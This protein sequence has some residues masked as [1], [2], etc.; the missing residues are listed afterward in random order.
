MSFA[1]SLKTTM[2]PELANFCKL[3]WYGLYEKWESDFYKRKDPIIKQ[4][5]W[6]IEAIFFPHPMHKIR[7]VMDIYIP[8]IYKE[9]NGGRLELPFYENDGCFGG[10]RIYARNANYN[11]IAFIAEKYGGKTQIMLT[12]DYSR[13]PILNINNNYFYHLKLET[14]YLKFDQSNGGSYEGIDVS[15]VSKW[16][17]WELLNYFTKF[18]QNNILKANNNQ[19]GIKKNST[20][21]LPLHKIIKI[22]IMD[23]FRNK[24][25]VRLIFSGQYQPEFYITLPGSWRVGNISLWRDYLKGKKSEGKALQ[26]IASS[27]ATSPKPIYLEPP[28]IS[29]EDGGKRKYGLIPSKNGLENY[30]FIKKTLTGVEIRYE[31]QASNMVSVFSLFPPIIFLVL[32]ISLLTSLIN[33]DKSIIT[34]MMGCYISYLIAIMAYYYT[35]ITLKNNGYD[36]PHR[37]LFRI[38]MFVIILAIIFSVIIIVFYK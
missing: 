27:S 32:S 18:I 28:I 24:I 30:E 20:K 19:V 23:F 8:V 9:S 21:K 5:W 16:I 26:F 13:L 36:V 12:P 15:P 29:R 37:I 1:D 33:S 10:L 34:S 14:E 2:T 22:I 25:K 31:A 7:Q 17:Y 11:E 3:K 35:Y 6:H 38:C 4:S